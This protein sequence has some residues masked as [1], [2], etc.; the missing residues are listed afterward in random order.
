MSAV[1]RENGI[2]YPGVVQDLL[3]RA[4]EGDAQAIDSLLSPHRPLISSYIGRRVRGADDREDLV[5]NVFLRAA[6]NLGSFRGDCPVSQWLLRIAANELKNYYERELQKRGRSVSLDSLDD[7]FDLDLQQTEPEAGPYSTLDAENT[8]SLVIE[9]AKT[10]CSGSEFRVIAM[11]YDGETYEGIGRLL[12]MKSAT[13]RS[14][15]LRGRAKLLAYLVQHEPGPLG[16]EEA[17]ER[18]REAASAARDPADRLDEEETAAFADPRG[19]SQAFR[20]ACL[21]IAKH[22]PV[23]ITVF[24]I[25]M[26]VFNWVHPMI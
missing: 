18:A 6:R 5:Q 9:A 1:R 12:D 14:H 25:L 26:E 10:A 22:L 3:V 15:F 11:F 21:K 4:R 13:V 20:G 24:G 19:R 17:I 2:H 16:G 23:P 8:I 7:A